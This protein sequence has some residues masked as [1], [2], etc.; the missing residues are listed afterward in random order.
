MAETSAVPELSL[1]LTL[2]A[3]GA[4]SKLWL[5]AMPMVVAFDMLEEIF[6]V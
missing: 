3:L 5:V 4:T 6:N 2:L 1:Y